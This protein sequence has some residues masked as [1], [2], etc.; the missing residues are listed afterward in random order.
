L[1]YARLFSF[2]QP[3]HL[4]FFSFSAKMLEL[5]VI[6]AQRAPELTGAL[7]DYYLLSQPSSH[8]HLGLEL[9]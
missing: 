2:V 7:C 9:G 8:V 6:K 4:T 1:S 5:C 3:A